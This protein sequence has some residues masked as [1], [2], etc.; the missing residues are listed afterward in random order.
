MILETERLYLREMTND[1]YDA[2]YAVLADSNI[3]QHYPCS[4]DESRVR[5]WISRNCERYAR[6]G[7]CKEN[8]NDKRTND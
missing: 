4:F 8:D 3:M 5:S 1:D 6:D 7:I 2:L